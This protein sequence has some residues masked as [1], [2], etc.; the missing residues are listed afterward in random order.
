MKNILFSLSIAV[1]LFACSSTDK[2]TTG[3]S[4]NLDS[5]MQAEKAKIMNDTANYT[6]LQWLDSTFLSMGTV[7]EGAQVEVSF[8]FKN[9]GTKPLVIANVT[10][11]CGCTIPET[12]QQPFAPGEEGVIKAKFDSKGRTGENRKHISVDANT[13]PSR[14]HDLEFTVDVKK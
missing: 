1:V 5:T 2:K 6:T 9:T 7:N 12:P 14:G 10:A 8:R 11:S 13:M 3:T 4:N